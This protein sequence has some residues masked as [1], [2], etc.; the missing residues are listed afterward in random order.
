MTP[1]LPLGRAR[2]RRP[3]TAPAGRARRPRS[4]WSRLVDRAAEAPTRVAAPLAPARQRRRRSTPRRRARR[5]HP[6]RARQ[7]DLVVPLA[8]ARRRRRPRPPPAGRPAWRVVAVDQLDMGFSERTGVERRLLAD[9]VA[10]PRRPHRRARPRRAPSSRSATTGAASSRWAGRSTTPSCSPRSMLLNTA[11]HQP[12]DAPIPAPLRLALARGVLGRATVGT[13]A[14]LETTLALA[15]PAAPGRG[16]GRLPRALPLGAP[17]GAASAGSS[18]T[19]RSTPR[20]RATP[21]STASPRRCA[22]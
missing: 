17:A 19:S 16:Q 12:A 22:T 1:R 15:P 13:P 11:I 21:S 6:L 4:A 3:A 18:P 9:R 14:F 2:A 10:R 5:H 20:T 7:P 8:R